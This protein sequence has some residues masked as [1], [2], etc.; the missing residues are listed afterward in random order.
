L[1]QLAIIFFTPLLGLAGLLGISATYWADTHSEPTIISNYNLVDSTQATV[2]SKSCLE[3]EHKILNS[4]ID[5]ESI[6]EE[7]NQLNSSFEIDY[8]SALI[9][10]RVGD[11]EAA[12]NSVLKHIDFK[13]SHFTFYDELITIARIS[14][15]LE[16]I[17][18]LLAGN[19]ETSPYSLYR[20]GLVNFESG[21]Y[22]ESISEF[23]KIIADGFNSEIVLYRLAY[24][25]R[26]IGDY[27]KSLEWL[28]EA[29]ALLDSSD[30]FLAKVINAK[31]SIYF[32]SSEYEIAEKFYI[33]ANSIAINS[34]NIVEE[35][36]SMGNLAMIKDFYGD[37][38]TAREDLS[39]AIQKASKIE[40]LDLL[41]FLHSELGVSFTYTSEN[42]KA[43]EN[44]ER[45]YEYYT[46]L[47]NH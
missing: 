37:V 30:Q 12:Y 17:K 11:Y 5:D 23:E 18:E 2:L 3:I 22:K 39:Y 6:K 33:E 46:T 9:Y 20:S 38:Y 24:S 25:N 34:G 35:I 32:L 8:L 13:T 47:Q 40:N 42:I 36:K 21:E 16:K 44:Y 27:Q 10:K 14:G 19:S 28:S 7:I 31:G 29:E 43:R 41:A 45:S 15:N 1:K 4:Q 26:L